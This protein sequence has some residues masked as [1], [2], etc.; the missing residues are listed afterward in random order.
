MSEPRFCWER[1]SEDQWMVVIGMDE[2]PPRRWMYVY[3][4]GWEGLSEKEL[5]ARQSAWEMG[6]L[7]NDRDAALE[8]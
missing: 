6:F 2:P 8:P 7:A 3:P 4:D 1:Q 5:E